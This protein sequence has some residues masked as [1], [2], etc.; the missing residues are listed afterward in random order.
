[1]TFDIDSRCG[2]GLLAA[3]AALIAMA[4]VPAHATDGYFLNGVGAKSKGMGGTA[5]ALPQEALAIAINPAAA[6]ELGHRVEVGV[7]VFIPDRGAQISGNGA[8]LNGSHSGNGANP[9]FLPDF[10]YVV[11]LND[12]TSFGM[13]IHGNGG[14]NTHYNDNPFAP[15]GASGYAGVDLAQVFITPTIATRLAEGHSVGV[16]L[17]GMVQVFHAKGIQPFATA[18]ADPANFSNNGKSVS[19]GAGFRVGYLGEVAKGVRIGAFYQSKIWAS[20]FKDYGGL[21]AD[22]GGFDVPAAYGAGIAVQATERLTLAGDV[23]R[24]EYSDIGSVGNPLT[25]LFSGVPFG[26]KDGPGFGWKDVNV[27]KLGAAYQVSN[28]LTLRA[29]Y[30]RSQNP[31]PANQTFLNILAPGV[32]TDHFT[33]GGSLAVAPDK[34][35]SVFVM[36]APNNTVRGSGSIPAPYGGGEADISLA[37]TAVGFGFEWTL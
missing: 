18:S 19:W 21:F 30:G 9:F 10:G 24:I 37:E 29:G 33:I 34:E 1:M 32:S 8:G 36:R 13:T 3:G 28:R 17:T 35:L 27:F 11:P 23:K 31:I 16:S 6:T 20:R 12:N 7:D 5:I 2:R 26:A 22:R 4:V 14:M 15:F 25:P